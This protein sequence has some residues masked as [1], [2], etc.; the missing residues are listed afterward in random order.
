MKHLSSRRKENQPSKHSSAERTAYS[1][2]MYI[3]MWNVLETA[4]LDGES[5]V[6]IRYI[7]YNLFIGK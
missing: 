1:L 6:H 2:A 5:P 7:A 4:A 3:Q